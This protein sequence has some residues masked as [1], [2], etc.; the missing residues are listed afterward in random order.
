[1]DTAP[2][3]CKADWECCAGIEDEEQGEFPADGRKGQ[4][5]F[6]KGLN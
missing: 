5:S 1:M 6:I 3:N 2:A 4:E